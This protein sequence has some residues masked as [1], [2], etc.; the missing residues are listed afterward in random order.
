MPGEHHAHSHDRHRPL[1]AAGWPAPVVRV[2]RHADVHAA[3]PAGR[4]AARPWTT[5]ADS[6]EPPPERVRGL[7]RHRAPPSDTER[8]GEANARPAEPEGPQERYELAFP[9]GSDG[10]QELVEVTRTSHT[11][12]GSHPVHEDATGIVRAEIS[13]RAEVRLLATGGQ[14]ESIRGIVARPPA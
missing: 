13:D 12:P 10:D 14:Q 6:P 8:V 5:A 1:P 3:A 2:R 7:R 4:A 11:G 9:A